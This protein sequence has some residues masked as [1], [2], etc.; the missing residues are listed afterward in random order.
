LSFSAFV[1]ERLTMNTAMLIA[2]PRKAVGNL[3]PFSML[4][5]MLTVVAAL[6]ALV[7]A[8]RGKLHRGELAIAI[9]PQHPQFLP[10]FAST[11]AW[12]CLIT[13]AAASSLVA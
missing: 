13:A 1:G 2:S 9:R 7:C 12:N 11:C 5:A 10:N 4:R 8:V 3:F 6:H